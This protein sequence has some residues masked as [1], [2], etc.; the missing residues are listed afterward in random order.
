[1]IHVDAEGRLRIHVSRAASGWGLKTLRKSF[2]AEHAEDAE[3]D[4]GFFSA[5][6]TL[7]PHSK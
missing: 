2:T 1:L 4:R 6:S 3:K 7:K 5:D